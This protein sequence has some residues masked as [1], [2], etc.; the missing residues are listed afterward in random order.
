MKLPKIEWPTA[1]VLVAVIAAIVTVWVTSPD[2]RGDILAVLGTVGAIV[3]AVMRALAS[4]APP[5]PPPPPA[6]TGG[7][8]DGPPT[9]PQRL[10][11]PTRIGG[12]AAR[13]GAF[14]APT[15]AF[16]GLALLTGCGASTLRVHASI[17]DASGRVLDSACSEARTARNAEQSALP[18]TREGATTH[19]MAVR[20]RWAPVIA[21]CNLVAEAHGGWADLVVHAAAGGAFDILSALSFAARLARAWPA[22]ASLTA[23]VGIPLPAPPD[24]L[25]RLGAATGG[26]L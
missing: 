3:L 6:A 19:V 5:P 7:D 11:R 22:L 16:L 2:H 10:S 18:E 12:D 25:L 4:G 8:T 14:L 20:A 21:T 26:A 15:L 1:A 23:A 24:E 13:S 9:T 17:L